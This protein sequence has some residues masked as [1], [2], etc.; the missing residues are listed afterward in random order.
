MSVSEVN[1]YILLLLLYDTGMFRIW[2]VL[3]L[4]GVEGELMRGVQ[5]FCVNSRASVWIGSFMCG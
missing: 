1:I 3:Q 2:K 4:L 5:R